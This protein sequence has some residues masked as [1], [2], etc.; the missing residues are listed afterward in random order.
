MFLMSLMRE[1]EREREKEESQGRSMT[2]FSAFLCSDFFPIT[3]N[4]SSTFSARTINFIGRVPPKQG[5]HH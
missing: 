1:R 4:K 3:K 2:N 5:L